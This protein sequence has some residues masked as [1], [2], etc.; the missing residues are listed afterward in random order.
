MLLDSLAL[1]S[2][3]ETCRTT[4]EFGGSSSPTQW[5]GNELWQDPVYF[6]WV[7]QKCPSLQ[8]VLHSL[9]RHLRNAELHTCA[10]RLWQEALLPKVSHFS[11]SNKNMSLSFIAVFELCIFSR[12]ITSLW[13]VKYYHNVQYMPSRF[14]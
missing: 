3:G 4:K 7:R 9:T 11:T 10:A 14:V 13:K 2:W 12:V 6:C 5:E 1:Q 8:S